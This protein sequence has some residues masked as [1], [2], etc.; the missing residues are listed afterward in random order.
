M[1]AFDAS[2][3]AALALDAEDALASYREQFHLPRA[4]GE[5]GVYLCGHSLGLQPKSARDYIDE[6]LQDWANLGVEGHFQARR[7]WL[8]YHETLTA[9][10]ARLVGARPAEVVVMNAL[11]V[12]LHLMLASFY[13]PTPER[14]KILIEADAFPSD[15]YATTSHIKWHG[16]DPQ[17]ALLTLRARPGEAN[18]RQEDIAALL[19]REGESIA[20][21]WLGGVNYYTGQV[22]DMAAITALGRAQGCAVGFDLAH[23]AGNIV[24][25]LHD[26]G[27]DCAVWCSYKYLNA[28]PGAAAGCFVHE[29]YANR[30]D[31]PRLAGWWGHNKD[32]RFHMPAEFDPIPGAEG[33]QISNPPILQL[34]ALRASMDIFDRVG[35]APLR[36]KSERL[37]GYLEALLQH[38]ALPGVSIITPAPPAQRGAQLSLQIERHGRALH[39]HLTQVGIICDWREPD[40]IR[41]A[42]APLYNTFTD[43]FTFVHALHGA[44]RE[45]FASSR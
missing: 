45:V 10:T 34:A 9:Q 16:Y 1:V 20:L 36:A 7:P 39:Q 15:R 31:L 19:R 5:P 24:L 22:F 8:S 41:V 2:R 17:E 12:N 3:E 40:V 4:Q 33:W 18:V 21:I 11:T 43:V 38:H 27:V 25:E 32:T 13:R 44:H 37:T 23:A 28:G 35:M 14:F 6:A 42:P 26:W 29:R 30:P